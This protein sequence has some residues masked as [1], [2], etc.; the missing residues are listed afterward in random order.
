MHFFRKYFYKHALRMRGQLL[1]KHAHG[2]GHLRACVCCVERGVAERSGCS[3]AH[4]TLPGV[5]HAP[6]TRR[7]ASG[8]LRPRTRRQGVQGAPAGPGGAEGLLSLSPLLV[9]SGVHSEGCGPG[10]PTRAWRGPGSEAQGAV[11]CSRP[12]AVWERAEVRPFGFQNPCAL[13]GPEES[14]Q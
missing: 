5:A 1:Q 8:P 12:P 3:Q 6:R 2:A 14:H 10:G 4:W 9:P 13:C 11:T 7:R